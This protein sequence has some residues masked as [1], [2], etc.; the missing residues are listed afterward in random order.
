MR[1]RVTWM[2][3]RSRGWHQL[4][5]RFSKCSVRS[6]RAP[7]EKPRGSA[8]CSLTYVFIFRNFLWGSVNYGQSL[9]GLHNT[10]SLRNPELDHVIIRRRQLRRFKQCRSMQS[11]DCGTNHAL[12]RCNLQITPRTL[13]QWRTEY[14]S[15]STLVAPTGCSNFPGCALKPSVYCSLRDGLAKS[16][17]TWKKLS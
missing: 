13:A 1:P 8:S 5:H 15:T 6:P 11:T 17:R 3:A 14:S 12:V 2:H 16:A 7:R 9:H 10:K 4:D